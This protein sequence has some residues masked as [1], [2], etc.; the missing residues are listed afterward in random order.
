MPYDPKKARDSVNKEFQL[1]DNKGEDQISAG[2]SK[3]WDAL[4]GKSSDDADKKKKKD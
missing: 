2:I 4:T 1:D 3:A